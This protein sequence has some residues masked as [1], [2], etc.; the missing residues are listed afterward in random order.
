[1]KKSKK[2]SA[3][4]IKKA[5]QALDDHVKADITEMQTY[6]TAALNAILSNSELITASAIYAKNLGHPEKLPNYISDSAWGYGISMFVARQ[7]VEKSIKGLYKN[8]QPLPGEDGNP[9]S[10]MQKFGDK[11]GTQPK[12]DL[13]GNN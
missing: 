3:A 13:H 7:K 6:A 1:M 4:S 10:A 5:D 9:L 8:G 2:P 11:A 12:T